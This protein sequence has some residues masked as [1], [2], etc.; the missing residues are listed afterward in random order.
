MGSSVGS[1]IKK[2]Q[3][4]VH[5]V[6]LIILSA[7]IL[8]QV[9]GL[10]NICIFLSFFWSFNLLYSPLYHLSSKGP[11]NGNSVIDVSIFLPQSKA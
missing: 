2:R 5:Q 3:K 10:H 11:L 8:R 9:Q 4:L 7:E 1:C 6:L